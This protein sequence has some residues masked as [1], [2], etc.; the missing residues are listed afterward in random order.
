M[1]FPALYN[2]ADEASNRAQS[3]FLNLVRA[4]YALLVVAAVLSMEPFKDI[5]SLTLY[6]LIF[7]VSLVVMLLRLFRTPDRDWYKC[8]ALAESIKTTSWR[9]AMRAH[10]FNDANA[11]ADRQDFRNFL[12]AIFQANQH[13]GARIA[14]LSPEGQQITNSMESKRALSLEDR[15]AYYLAHRIQDQ[16]IWY[17]KKSRANKRALRNWI[18]IC[19]LVYAAAATSVLLRIRFPDTLLFTEPLIVIASSFVGWT[20][21]RKYA[22]LASSYSLASHEIGIIEGRVPEILTETDF[23]NFVNEAELAFSRE[24][25]QWVARQ[26]NI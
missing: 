15:R 21:I 9:Y 22:E 11:Q 8:R 10:P 24:H 23:S 13:I 26:H 4:E 1:E 25:T 19:S 14:G 3:E 16:R 6:A 2:D 7:V 5:V 20:Q 17:S 18:I 12:R